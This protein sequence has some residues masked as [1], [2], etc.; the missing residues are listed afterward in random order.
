MAAAEIVR[1]GPDDREAAQNLFRVLAEV[2]D[3]D[4]PT[5]TNSYVDQ[6]LRRPDLWV[7]A[8]IVDQKIVGGATAHLLPLTRIESR[9]L[10]LYD[11][12]VRPEYQRQGIGR[13]LLTHLRACASRCGAQEVFVAAECEDQHAIDFYRACGGKSNDVV[14]FTF[15]ATP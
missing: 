8:A 7:L 12:A 5:L 11:L 6:L 15:E 13:Q 2:F 14:H 10:Y 3:E 9:E 4:R 1:L